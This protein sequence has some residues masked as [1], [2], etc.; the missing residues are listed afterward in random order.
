MRGKL[1]HAALWKHGFK[2]EA[3]VLS[4]LNGVAETFDCGKLVPSYRDCLCA[5]ARHLIYLLLGPE[6]DD[7]ALS[8]VSGGGTKK[9]GKSKKSCGVETPLLHRFLANIDAREQLVKKVGH[10]F[11]E[12]VFGTDDLENFFSEVC[13]RARSGRQAPNCQTAM[14]VARTA[15]RAAKLLWDGRWRKYESKRKRYTKAE[16]TTHVDW[17]CGA[18]VPV[19]WPLDLPT[20]VEVASNSKVHAERRMHK[21]GCK[22]ALDNA[23]KVRS[24]HAHAG[25]DTALP[26]S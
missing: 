13:R 20:G 15:E 2:R 5:R 6:L 18:R 11:I 26:T 10:Y 22:K 19:W 25:A 21:E 24:Y 8:A 16:R 7:C 23:S 17:H 4:V 3:A 9:D 14:L 1:F 12:R